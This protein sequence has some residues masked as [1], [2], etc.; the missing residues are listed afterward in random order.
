MK[1]GVIMA[2]LLVVLGVFSGTGRA[3]TIVKGKVILISGIS[4]DMY[5]V[6]TDSHQGFGGSRETFYV[7]PKSTKK[8]GEINVGTDVEAEINANG[9]AYWIKA[10]NEAKP[11][12]KPQ[13]KK[14]AAK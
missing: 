2:I 12:P 13:A 1:S 8:T 14:P 3:D 6:K 4:N 10:V 11:E 9:T 7:D 5:T